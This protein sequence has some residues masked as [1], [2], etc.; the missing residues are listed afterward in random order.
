MQHSRGPDIC[1]ATGWTETHFHRESPHR[2]AG[3]QALLVPEFTGQ[4]LRGH[5]ESQPQPHP[6]ASL[7]TAKEVVNYTEAE[8]LIKSGS[9]PLS[10]SV[11]FHLPKG[12]NT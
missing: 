1:L 7:T 6:P 11:C 10:K 4:S 12:L 2:P 8:G 9:V 5:S 3:F